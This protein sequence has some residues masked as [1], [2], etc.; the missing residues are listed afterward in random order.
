MTE[1]LAKVLLSVLQADLLDFLPELGICGAIVF[2]LL[3]RLV[4]RYDQL[5]L[6]WL[7]L[8]RLQ[9]VD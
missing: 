8:L 7:A 5:H 3:V 2:F 1:D 4:P 6:G 9:A